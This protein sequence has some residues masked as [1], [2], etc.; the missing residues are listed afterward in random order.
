MIY[1]DIQHIGKPNNPDDMGASK[2]DDVFDNEA[3]WTSLYAFYMEMHLR[4]IGYSVMRLCDGRYSDRHERVNR[5]EA[6]Y[7]SSRPSVYL[8]C[9]INGGGGSYG[10]YFYDH[11]SSLGPDLAAAIADEV[12]LPGISAA[13]TLPASPGD[14]TRNAYA[15]I[16]DVRR[17]VSICLE[18][19][20]IDNPAHQ[21][22]MDV[23][24]I[25]LVGEAIANGIHSWYINQGE[26]P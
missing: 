10:A 19:F 5:Y 11:R 14:W 8:S 17:P 18:P 25:Y 20:F 2:G 6:D 1:I 4:H 9:H 13:K 21:R 15:T 23:D 22:Y 26:Q 3:Y 16:K 7:P 12:D 24:K